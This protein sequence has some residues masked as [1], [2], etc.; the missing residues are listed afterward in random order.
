MRRIEFTNDDEK[1]IIHEYIESGKSC[2]E[3]S[4]L[5]NISKT[6]INSILKKLGLLRK[7]KSNGRK[8]DL[9]EEQKNLIKKYYIEQ[10]KNTEEISNKLGLNK[11]FIDKYLNGSNFRR[12]KGESI[13]LRQTGKKHTKERVESFKLVQQ[14]LAESGKRKQRGGICKFFNIKGIECQGTYEKFYIEKLINENKVLPDKGETIKTPY[15]VYSS[16]FSKDNNLIEIKSDYT[17]DVL[18][19]KK[20]SRFTKKI[21]LIQ[22]NKIKWVNENVKPVEIIVVDK[23]QNKLIKKEIK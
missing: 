23:R 16:D 18:I 11:H 17:Y 6:P 15:G 2:E 13:T 3:I 22:Y 4:K 20:V 8:I 19:G 10:Y 14:K 1:L 7:G 21:D 5:F 9:T 12:N